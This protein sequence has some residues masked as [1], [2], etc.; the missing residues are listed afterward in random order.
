MFK[1]LTSSFFVD[2]D[3]SLLDNLPEVTRKYNS[4]EPLLNQAGWITYGR[5]M[6]EINT[7]HGTI[8]FSTHTHK[9]FPK[10][11]DDVMDRL[12]EFITPNY[13]WNKNRIRLIRTT[14]YILSHTDEDRNSCINVG[15]FNSD[16]AITHFGKNNSFA[17]FDEPMN[18]STY[19]CNDGDAYLLNVSNVHAVYPTTG[20]G[21]R[22][23]ITYGFAEDFDYLSRIL[24]R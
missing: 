11:T 24:V 6:R 21:P 2:L 4:A 15:L 20:T 14:G 5:P 16:T 19:R 17:D 18:T 12:H 23:L 9:I 1:L 3:K 13:T 7:D 8:S 10:F 22:Y